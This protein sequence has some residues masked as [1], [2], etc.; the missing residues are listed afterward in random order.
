MNNLALRLY[1]KVQN[2][3]TNE[4]GQ[5]LVEYALVVAF[6]SLAVITSVKGVATAVNTVF[7]NVSNSL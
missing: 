2:L 1:I 5:D 6:I 3:A 4:H 7:S